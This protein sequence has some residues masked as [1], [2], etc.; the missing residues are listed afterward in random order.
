MKPLKNKVYDFY[1]ITD[2]QNNIQ[3]ICAYDILI[4]KE[5]F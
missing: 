4:F 1:S 5:N 2:G 3:T